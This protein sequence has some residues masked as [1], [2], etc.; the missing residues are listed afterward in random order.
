MSYLFVRCQVECGDTSSIDREDKVRSILEKRSSNNV[1]TWCN[2][3][4]ID[5]KPLYLVIGQTS[6]LARPNR[7]G[8]S[9]N[10]SSR[11]QAW[12]RTTARRGLMPTH[13]GITP[14]VADMQVVTTVVAR[15]SAPLR[16]GCTKRYLRRGR[17]EKIVVLRQS[18]GYATQA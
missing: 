8:T 18:R 1:R 10:H 12:S 3:G 9:S 15:L 2:K 5:T 6:S 4:Q 16:A 11:K 14:H 7:H 17:V 13:K